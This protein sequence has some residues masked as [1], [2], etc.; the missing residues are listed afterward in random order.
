MSE[1]SSCGSGVKSFSLPKE[2][3][4]MIKYLDSIDE[5]V[6]IQEGIKQ[7]EILSR[8]NP[9]SV[10]TIRIITH[11]TNKGD[12]KMRSAILRMGRKNSIVDNASSGGVT[13]G[14]MPD[15]RL[16]PEGYDVKGNRYSCH[17]DSKI[18]FN[19]IV[20]PNFQK[21]IDNIKQMQWFLPQFRMPSWDIAIDSEGNPRIVEVNMNKGQLEFHQL[22]NGPIFGEDTEEVLKEV[23][24]K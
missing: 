4:Q 2:K 13:V 7:H 22:D 9:E 12:V 23:F 8:L 11:L 20:I 5:N 3:S 15:G 1:C 14:I 6:V 17:P 21:L 24:T 18:K 16:K 10:N 19:E